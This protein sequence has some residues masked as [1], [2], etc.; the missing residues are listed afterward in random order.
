MIQ[1]IDFYN[2]FDRT[3]KMDISLRKTTYQTWHRKDIK[4]LWNERTFHFI[5]LC[6]FSRVL[7]QLLLV[8]NIMSFT[9]EFSLNC[10]H[11]P[12]WKAFYHS[13][14]SGVIV[15]LWNICFEASSSVNRLSGLSI[16]ITFPHY[17][18]DMTR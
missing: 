5:Q 1:C 11:T 4:H 6:T 15:D 8:W 17:S 7:T 18:I 14:I 3:D 16:N 12:Q 9:L 10:L 2:E 13:G